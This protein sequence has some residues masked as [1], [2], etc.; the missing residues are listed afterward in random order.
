MECDSQ[1][2]QKHN[3]LQ[4]MLVGL[5]HVIVKQ[6][7]KNALRQLINHC[8]G[9]NSDGEEPYSSDLRFT[10]HLKSLWLRGE[11]SCI[12]CYEVF[13]A[14]HMLYFQSG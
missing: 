10:A 12:Q 3:R 9:S 11:C 1:R 5:F 7:K 2:T 6:K 8:E 14:C 13:L 4:W